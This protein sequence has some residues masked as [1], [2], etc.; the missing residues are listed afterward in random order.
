[1]RVVCSSLSTW[2][3]LLTLLFRCQAYDRI[4]T[5]LANFSSIFERVREAKPVAKVPNDGRKVKA[6]KSFRHKNS[7]QQAK[8][9]LGIEEASGQALL[10]VCAVLNEKEKAPIWR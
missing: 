3:L 2:L 1:M 5:R 4:P 9:R 7:D 10:I 6:D 8:L